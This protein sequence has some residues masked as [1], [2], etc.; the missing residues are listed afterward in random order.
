MPATRRLTR[1]EKK[2]ETRSRL[3]DAAV[4]VCLEKGITDATL[5]EIAERAGYSKGAVYSNFAGKD[6]LLLA[7]F[8]DRLQTRAAESVGLV[9]GQ[10]TPEAVAEMAAG[11]SNMKTPEQRAYMLLLAEFWSYAARN[12]VA[13]KRFAE[14]R[15]RYR[16]ALAE[17]VEEQAA[18]TGATLTAPAEHVA[19]GVLSV[20]VGMVLEHLVGDDLDVAGMHRS[21]IQL[22]YRGAFATSQPAAKPA[23]T[24]R[25]KPKAVKKAAY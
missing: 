7:V 5:D 6:D 19:A 14:N 12:E 21:I 24:R 9:R 2:A 23:S 1:E 13:R 11:M 25:S 22:L 16:E 20:S 4:E 3:V 15:K 18:A 8:E 17:L 10:A